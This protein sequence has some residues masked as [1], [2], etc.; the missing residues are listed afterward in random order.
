MYFKHTQLQWNRFRIIYKNYILLI[1]FNVIVQ[2][3]KLSIIGLEH[4]RVERLELMRSLSQNGLNS[5]EIAD[6]LNTQNIKSPR[7]LKYS[8][9]LVWVSLNKYLKRLERY[10]ADIQIS[11]S[12]ELRIKP[13]R[14]INI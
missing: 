14:I 1:N 12:E 10:D 4:S 2:T 11:F 9:K 8:P 5:V 13:L 7:G 6:Y 3:K